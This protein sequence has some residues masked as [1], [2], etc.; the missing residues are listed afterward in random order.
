MK[1]IIIKTD[2]V[3]TF[4]RTEAMCRALEYEET[5]MKGRKA[6]RYHSMLWIKQGTN[7][8]Y[9]FEIYHTKTAIVVDIRKKL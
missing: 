5:H 1:K 7:S 6:G 3:S 4:L 2:E 9:R 8:E